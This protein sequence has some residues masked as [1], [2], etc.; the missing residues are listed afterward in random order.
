MNDIKIY[1]DVYS[2]NTNHKNSIIKRYI[3]IYNNI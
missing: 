3:S 2:N 1:I